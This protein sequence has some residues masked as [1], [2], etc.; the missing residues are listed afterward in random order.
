MKRFLL[1]PLFFI[2]GFAFAQSVCVNHTLPECGSCVTGNATVQLSNVTIEGRNRIATDHG[3]RTNPVGGNNPNCSLQVG[4]VHRT[5]ITFRS[6]D[7]C[8]E[9]IYEYTGEVNTV[10]V[11][12]NAG[13]V[14]F[15]NISTLRTGHD[16]NL[17]SGC[18]NESQ[19]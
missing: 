15:Q 18:G 11:G 2:A 7:D 17:H 9:W 19:N 4:A 5:T 10:S 16:Q 14:T 13:R 6:A 1:I 12:T 3:C 8:Q